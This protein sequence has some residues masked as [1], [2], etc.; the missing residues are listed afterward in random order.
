MV[1]R[2]ALALGAAT[3]L[4]MAAPVWAQPETE[5]VQPV[6]VYLRSARIALQTAP[7]EYARAMRNLQIARQHYPENFDVHLMLGTVWAEKDE[8]DSMVAEYALAQKY[9]SP[10]DWAKREK[11]LQ[12]VIDNKWL[13]RFNRAVSLLGQSD[14]IS[15]LASQAK[16]ST[17][18]DSLRGVTDQIRVM[19]ADALR[20]CLLLRPGDFRAPATRGLLYQRKGNIDSSLAD[21]ISAE[22]MFHRSEF[23][24]STTDWYDTTTF[25]RG[26]EGEKTDAYKTFEGKYKKLTEEKRTRYNNLM[27]SLAAAYYDA[28]KWHE[29]VAINRRYHALFPKDIN[30]IVTLADVFSRLGNDDEAFKWQES[31]VRE[32]PSS[33]DTWYNM[34]IFYYNTAIRLQDS[35]V[36]AEKGADRYKGA[37]AAKA[38]QREF[39]RKALEN[40]VRAVPRFSKVVEID[41]KDQDTWR[42]LAVCYYSSSSLA[43]DERLGDT[44]SDRDQYLRGLWQI[45][46]G[47]EGAWNQQEIWETTRQTLEKALQYFPDDKGLCRMM[48]VTLAQLNRVDDLKAW[49]S[50]CP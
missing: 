19:S 6:D 30:A 16:D 17:A 2:R 37:E 20:Q 40:F 22:T 14:S 21:F 32:D 46:R 3:I 8:V 34:G 36:E 12:K 24:D 50:K 13:D 18:A 25:F 26:A 45:L 11:N 42:L 35:L 31:V 39:L 33:K 15:D 28:Q 47:A 5:V 1:R 41:A 38:A 9:A 10:Q 27:R 43:T 49:D 23:G 48:K 29:C 44:P 4:L 7:P